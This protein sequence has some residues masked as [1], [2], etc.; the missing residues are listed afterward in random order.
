MKAAY[1]GDVENDCASM[2]SRLRKHLSTEPNHCH[3]CRMR[4]LLQFSYRWAE[5]LQC[6]LFRY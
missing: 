4:S 2:V 5:R 1:L 6:E 3:Q